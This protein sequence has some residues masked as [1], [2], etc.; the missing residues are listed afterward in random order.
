M[1]AFHAR[2]VERYRGGDQMVLSDKDILKLQDRGTPLISPFDISRLRAASY[3]VTIDDEVAVLSEVT[4]V[5]NLSD[6]NKVN[7]I[8]TVN[9]G[10]EGFVLKP[11]QYCLVALSETIT[12]PDNLIAQVIP[13]TRFTRL[14]LLVAPQYCNPSY[15]G[16]LRIGILNVSGNNIQLEPKMSIAQIIFERLET[17]PTEQRLYRNQATAAYQGEDAFVGAQTRSEMTD[18][19]RRIFDRLMA[20]AEAGA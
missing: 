1:V 19:A 10:L 20:G 5:V 18:G 17:T 2:F 16:R 11:G 15:T 4:G 8:Y 7:Q 12:L 3:D 14:G 6:Q 9:H 13:R